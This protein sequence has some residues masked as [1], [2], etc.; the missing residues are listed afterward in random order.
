MPVTLRTGLPK[1]K[2]RASNRKLAV[3]WFQIG[4]VLVIADDP[5]Q[6]G[7]RPVLF[8]IEAAGQVWANPGMMEISEGDLE[9]VNSTARGFDDDRFVAAIIIAEKAYKPVLGAKEDAKARLQYVAR[10]GKDAFQLKQFDNS[11]W[12]IL[13]RWPFWRSRRIA[14]WQDRLDDFEQQSGSKQ[15]KRWLEKRCERLGLMPH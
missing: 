10:D 15:S 13:K 6:L 4:D 5:L 8:L 7:P 12:L 2:Q 11:D 1:K 14:N 9:R 3:Y